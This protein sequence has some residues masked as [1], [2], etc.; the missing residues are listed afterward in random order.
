M[1]TK[2]VSDGMRREIT[3][4]VALMDHKKKRRNENKIFSKQNQLEFIHDLQPDPSSIN[5]VAK[6]KIKFLQ[7]DI[8]ERYREVIKINGQNQKNKF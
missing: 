2:R 8:E 4:T 1:A 6:S 7:Q 3:E 5:K